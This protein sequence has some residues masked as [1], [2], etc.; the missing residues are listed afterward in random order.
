MQRSRAAHGAARW[1]ALVLPVLGACAY[2]WSVG[3]GAGGAGGSG[4]ASMVRDAGTDAREHDAGV[5]A[6]PEA[7]RDAA[8]EA[9]PDCATIASQLASAR[10]AAKACTLGVAGQ[11]ATDVV[12]ECGCKSYVTT[13]GSAATAYAQAV[14]QFTG[15][16]CVPSCTTCLVSS[17]DCLLS[18]GAQASCIP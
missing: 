5:D 3:G 13:P 11:C 16:H 10:S 8:L 1:S 14:E 9:G 7:G 18:G 12:D 4:G 15:A 2:D 17:G 6:A